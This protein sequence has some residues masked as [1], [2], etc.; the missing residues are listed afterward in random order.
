MVVEII[1]NCLKWFIERKLFT[2]PITI[3][4]IAMLVILAI[5]KAGVKEK[6]KIGF[7]VT[8][9][10]LIIT[11]CLL[12]I[13]PAEEFL[14]KTKE[15]FVM[16]NFAKCFSIFTI[17]I[18]IMITVAIYYYSR[19][20]PEVAVFYA[21][22]TGTAIGLLL[23]P[24]SVDILG[25]FVAWELLSVPLY[26]MVAYTANWEKG[27]EGAMKYFIMGTTSSGI[28][29]LGVGIIGSLAGTTNLYAL[30]MN[31]K[32]ASNLELILYVLGVIALLCGFGV[33]ITL[34][35]LHQWAP[36][37]YE[38]AMPPVTAYLSGAIK[39]V[40]FTAPLRV[41]MLLT[42][43]LRYNARL[44]LAILAFLTMTYGNIVALKQRK[45][46]RMLAYSSIA[47][48]GY[49]AI[50]L[51][52]GTELGLAA[53]IFYLL[54]FAIM[55]AIVFIT[56]G[57]V[58]LYL[59]A[60]TIDDYNGLYDEYPLVAVIMMCGLLS[61]VGL[62]PFAGFPGKVMLFI[63]AWQIGLAWLAIALAINS[64]IS[65]GYYGL[66][67]KRMFLD[68]PSEKVKVRVKIPLPF[69][70]TLI[71]LTL[72]LVFFGVWPKSLFDVSSLGAKVLLS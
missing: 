28:L 11:E 6:D 49:V 57:I 68:E 43:L 47:Q 52:A 64:G 54:I 45:V 4:T 30:S 61:L 36:D 72:L 13:L 24:A 56:A 31:I 12:I 40:R 21:L 35:P 3:L 5:E 66:L 50:G 44:F 10:S 9:A 69:K 38:G 58:L 16:D 23:L 46:I 22:I 33:K 17:F 55:E 15:I 19:G 7:I 37:T 41:F 53:S 65:I 27:I 20:L 62:P 18:T 32:I 59:K 48:M 8:L 2:W 14:D 42:P 63:A 70:I 39:V 71:I 25:V 67:I 29:A 60:E 1:T 26:I 51:V 34:V